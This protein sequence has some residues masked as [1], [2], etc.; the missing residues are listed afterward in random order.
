MTFQEKYE[1]AISKGAKGV[2]IYNR[3]G[4]DSLVSMEISINKEVPIL[5]I[6]NSNGIELLNNINNGVKYKFEDKGIVDHVE[7]ENTKDMSDFT[8][9]G[10]TP[11]L[12]FKPEIAA[13]GGEIFSLANNNSYQSMSGTSMAAPHT[14]GAEALVL[15]GIKNKGL[16]IANKDLVLFAKNVVMN[17]AKIL[18]DKYDETGTIP[19][20]PRRQGAGLIQIEDAIKNNV[21]I[22]GEDGK[23]AVALKEVENSKKFTLKLK[24][25]G[26]KDVTYKLNTEKVYGE[27]VDDYGL[28]HEVELE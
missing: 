23:A 26:D 22:T 21:L 1:N 3:D 19:Y 2:I 5:F 24:N 8:S 25:Y 10:P 13:P 17:T 15:Q 14:A 27:N 12:D 6:P 7:N 11:N 4:D 18:I 9:W 28:I 20:S 16:E